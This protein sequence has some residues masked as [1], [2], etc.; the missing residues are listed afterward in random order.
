MRGQNGILCSECNYLGFLSNNDALHLD[1]EKKGLVI[2]LLSWAI[3]SNPDSLHVYYHV[4]TSKNRRVMTHII[5]HPNIQNHKTLAKKLNR[6]AN[7]L[8][9]NAKDDGSHA[10]MRDLAEDHNRRAKVYGKGRS[11]FIFIR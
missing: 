8:A 5:R 9:S 1:K 2:G 10:T 4:L 6:I 7:V 3:V 11:N